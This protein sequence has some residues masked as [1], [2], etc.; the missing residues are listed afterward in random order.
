MDFIKSLDLKC[1]QEHETQSQ[2]S[3]PKWFLDEISDSESVSS[4]KLSIEKMLKSN[5]EDLCKRKSV[6][7]AEVRIKIILHRK[8]KA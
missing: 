5:H 7:L 6:H 3:V 4:V 2:I 1:F 8:G